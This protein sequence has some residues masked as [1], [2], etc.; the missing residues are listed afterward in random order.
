MN[1]V[2]CL[3]LIL[4]LFACGWE[5]EITV[6]S[7]TVFEVKNH[8]AKD[9]ACVVKTEVRDD[10]LYLKPQ[11]IKKMSFRKEE[12]QVVETFPGGEH[13]FDLVEHVDYS[14]QGIYNLTDTSK[15]IRISGLAASQQDTLFD[16]G[17]NIWL[18]GD[19][20]NRLVNVVF[21]VTDT[22][23]TITEKDYTML[24]KFSEYYDR[25]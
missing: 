24:D 21:E 1:K 17:R 23:L 7:E 13:L 14:E 11:D 22:L 15:Y 2:L 25:Q 6:S 4:L 8:S 10:L 9:I 12:K 20:L 18:E 16:A 19:A 5:K 3:L